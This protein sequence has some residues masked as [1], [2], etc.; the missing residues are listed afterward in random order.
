MADARQ[1]PGPIPRPAPIVRPG[2]GRTSA[3]Q[4]RAEAAKAAAEAKRIA[5]EAEATRARTEQLRIEGQLRAAERAA[6]QQAKG[7]T[8]GERIW[9][10]GLTVGAPVAGAG[11][12]VVFAK[13]IE[14]RHAASLAAN[15]K[16]VEALG[17][18][19]ARIMRQPRLSASATARLQGIVSTAKAMNLSKVRGPLGV[20]TAALFLAEGAFS[21]FV[22]APVVENEAARDVLRAVGTGSIFA[23]GNLIG[24]RM[25]QNATLKAVP[26]AQHLATIAAAEQRVGGAKVAAAAAEATKAIATGRF[27]RVL[28]GASRVAG[29]ALGAGGKV[30]LPLA[31]AGAAIG[32]Y[33][34]YQREGAKGALIGAGDSLTFGAVSAL[35]RLAAERGGGRLAIAQSAATRVVTPEMKRASQLRVAQRMGTGSTGWTKAYTRNQAGR[36]VRVSGYKTPARRGR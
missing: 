31:V 34:G 35:R 2:E 24:K 30:F 23:A 15:A 6:E 13:G 11:L 28:G 36:L 3:R 10:A 18:M 27:A 32:A 29:V 20:G 4:S 26:A 5:A 21:R 8:V 14:K 12:G 25:L 16:Q 17:S 9:Q 22:A 33:H 7:R 1:S 19:A